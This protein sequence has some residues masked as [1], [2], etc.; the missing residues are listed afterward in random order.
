MDKQQWTAIT[1]WA[2]IL[3]LGFGVSY[4]FGAVVSLEPNVTEWSEG[5]RTAWLGAGLSVVIA[6]LWLGLRTVE[7]DEKE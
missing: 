6:R 1:G 7:P 5:A 4:A 3:F 2:I